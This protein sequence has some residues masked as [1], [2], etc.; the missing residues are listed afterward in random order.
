[1]DKEPPR[2]ISESETAYYLGMSN[3]EFSRRAAELEKALGL[4]PR[5]PALGKRDRI[6][7]DMWIDELF[8]VGRERTGIGNLIR[9]RMRALRGNAAH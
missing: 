7:I 3:S 2:L 4:P 6:A 8:G 1:M 5:H 9:E